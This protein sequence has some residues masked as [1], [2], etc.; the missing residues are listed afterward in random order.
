MLKKKWKKFI[1]G[2]VIRFE[3]L[4][5]II[6]RKCFIDKF[7]IPDNGVILLSVGELNGNKNHAAVIEALA[8]IKD[9]KL[10]Y[11][12]AGAGGL[13]DTLREM[14]KDKGVNLHLLG[15]YDNVPELMSI[16]DVFVHLS[17]REG[18]PVALM[19]AMAAGLPVIASN[20]RGVQD[21][22]DDGKGGYLV[23]LSVM[24]EIVNTIK[25]ISKTSSVWKKMGK[26]NIRVI[27][28]FDREKVL[29]TMK[30][31]YKEFSI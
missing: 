11:C 26:Y 30:K 28:D 27:Q 23:K 9:D 12:I 7:G 16:A 19:E 14:A 4:Q 17:F 25:K 21:L 31:E 5:N 10:H 15:Y 22:I 24:S 13:E 2:G 18:L 3:K 8:Q 1:G 6:R 29:E 20:I